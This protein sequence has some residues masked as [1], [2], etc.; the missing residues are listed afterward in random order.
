MLAGELRRTLLQAEERSG[1]GSYKNVSR[2]PF[3][4]RSSLPLSNCASPSFPCRLVDS[5]AAWMI[6]LCA[7]A[8]NVRSFWRRSVEE[9]PDRRDNY[10][11]AWIRLTLSLHTVMLSTQHDH[12]P[13][14]R[15]LGDA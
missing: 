10:L 1:F 13:F 11:S 9:L 6:V 12:G 4:K 15:V 3:K 2:Y 14:W 5:L 7:T 8:A